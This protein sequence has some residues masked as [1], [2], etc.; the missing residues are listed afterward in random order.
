M[1]VLSLDLFFR[2]GRG[3]CCSVVFIVRLYQAGYGSRRG[4]GS[5]PPEAAKEQV[6]EDV[7]AAGETQNNASG[8]KTRA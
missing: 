7:V 8:Q 4:L 6:S 5:R 2:K 1:I 3:C